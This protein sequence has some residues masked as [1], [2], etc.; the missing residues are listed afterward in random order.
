MRLG[1]CAVLMCL[2]QAATSPL[3]WAQPAAQ[4]QAPGNVLEDLTR[5]RPLTPAAG[6]SAASIPPA[7]TTI[8]SRTS[9]PASAR[10]SRA[11]RARA[12]SI[13]SGSRSRRRRPTLSRH[14]II[15][16]MY[17]DDEKEPSVEAPIGEF[18]G[19]GWNESYPFSSL[20]LAAGPREGRALVS[21][22]QMPF[23]KSARV[24]IEND[25]GRAIDAF[26]YYI[27]Y[28]EMKALPP[29]TAYFHA[30]YNQKMTEAP[31]SGENEWSVLGRKARTPTASATTSSPI[32]K[33]A[34]TTLAST[35]S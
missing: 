32:S 31:P 28:V 17:W 20:P 15:L 22:F 5:L 27:D 2:A 16:R 14:D 12:S 23:A 11:S 13:T 33:A 30:W 35:T 24:E 26:Y 1:T 3:A 10:I 18:F 29:N 4:S 6:A 9:P 8:A 19:Q 7:A 21:Y 25:S 34:A